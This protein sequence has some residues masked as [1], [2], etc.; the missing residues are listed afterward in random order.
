[1]VGKRKIAFNVLKLFPGKESMGDKMSGSFSDNAYLLKIL[2]FFNGNSE[3]CNSTK[4][5]KHKSCQS[6]LGNFRAKNSKKTHRQIIF[7]NDLPLSPILIL[8]ATG[9]MYN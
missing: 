8:K 1:L 6:S 2:N 7:F 3:I 4:G 5:A 9:P